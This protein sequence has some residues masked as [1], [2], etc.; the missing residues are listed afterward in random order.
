LVDCTFHTDGNDPQTFG[1]I[2]YGIRCSSYHDPN[3]VDDLIHWGDNNQI[4]T[5]DGKFLINGNVLISLF[6]ILIS[7]EQNKDYVDLVLFDAANTFIVNG[8][9]YPYSKFIGNRAEVFNVLGL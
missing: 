6:L 7:D 8:T 5:K 4:G 9:E 2:I 3:E 1:E